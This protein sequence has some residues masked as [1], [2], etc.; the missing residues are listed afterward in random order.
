M[1]YEDKL[2]SVKLSLSSGM[3][4]GFVVAFLVMILNDVGEAESRIK[5]IT[6][7]IFGTIFVIVLFVG[8]LWMLDRLFIKTHKG[9]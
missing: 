6:L 5:A 1:K 9:D 2:W 4:A 7:L 8:G 3:I